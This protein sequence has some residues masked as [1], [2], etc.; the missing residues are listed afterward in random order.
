M[1]GPRR[2]P[3]SVT[4]MPETRIEPA[5][6]ADEAAAIV[7]AVD[8]LWPQPMAIAHPIGPQSRAWRFSGRWWMRDRRVDADRPWR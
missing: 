4:G 7:A 1:G 3:A 6:T 5:P 8:A 2:C